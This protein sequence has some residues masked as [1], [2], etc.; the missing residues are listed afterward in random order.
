MCC[1]TIDEFGESSV[2]TLTA[3]NSHFQTTRQEV[4]HHRQNGFNTVVVLRWILET[5]NRYSKF[6]AS[7]IPR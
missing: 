2:T 3:Q 7:D 5:N 4:K 1:D 6:L